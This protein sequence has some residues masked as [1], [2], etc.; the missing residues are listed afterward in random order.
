[1]VLEVRHNFIRDH[2][3]KGE[4]KIVFVT[5]SGQL[6]YIFTTPLHKESLFFISI[7]IEVLNN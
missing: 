7:E 3:E 6:T 2:I 1:M 5:S 4:C